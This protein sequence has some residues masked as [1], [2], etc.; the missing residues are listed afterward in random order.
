MGGVLVMGTRWTKA[1]RAAGR[2]MIATMKQLRAI[3]ASRGLVDAHK[4]ASLHRDLEIAAEFIPVSFWEIDKD[5]R[6]WRGEG[7]TT[8]EDRTYLHRRYLDSLRREEQ[9]HRR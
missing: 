4:I 5:R 9:E 1:E 3:R 6:G 2:L 7:P 8:E